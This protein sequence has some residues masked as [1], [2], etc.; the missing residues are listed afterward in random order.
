MFRVSINAKKCINISHY[1]TIIFV[2]I[3]FIIA[4]VPTGMVQK[5]TSVLQRYFIQYMSGFDLALLK[6]IVPVR[7]QLNFIDLETGG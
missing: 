7:I 4:I 6:E 2:I 1:I 5:Y 3:S